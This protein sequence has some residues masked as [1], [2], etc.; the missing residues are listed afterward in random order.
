M[1]R[2]RCLRHRNGGAARHTAIKRLT[3]LCSTQEK[4]HRS[5]LNVIDNV[6]GPCTPFLMNI[7]RFLYP[8]GTLLCSK[9]RFLKRINRYTVIQFII[10][11]IIFVIRKNEYTIGP[12]YTHIRRTLNSIGRHQIVIGRW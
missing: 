6:Y 8:L 11:N 3:T 5:L 9:R 1:V 4:G 10:T 2:R 12:L 7:C